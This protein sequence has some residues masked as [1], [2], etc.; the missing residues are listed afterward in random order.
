MLSFARFLA[1]LLVF[2]AST[3][4]ALDLPA[5][6]AVAAKAWLL[7]DTQSGQV[8]Q[9]HAA[10]ERMEPASLTKLM[11]AYVVFQ[12][13]RENRITLTQAVPVS[14]KAWKAQGS[15][16]FIQPRLPVT[17]EELIKGMIIQSGNDAC[18]AL[19]EVIAG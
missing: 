8:V 17:V 9:S 7:L 5:P 14:E 18:I 13:L 16:M 4:S 2:L 10:D 15:R 1:A 6:P 19:A 3:A 12:A 11:T